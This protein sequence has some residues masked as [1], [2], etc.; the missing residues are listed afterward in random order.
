[1][2]HATEHAAPIF[3]DTRSVQL[4]PGDVRQRVRAVMD[5]FS[6]ETANSIL[7]MS[8]IRYRVLAERLPKARAA[9]IRQLVI[10]GAGLDTTAFALPAGAHDWRVF[11]VDHPATQDWKRA[12][13]ANLGWNTPPNLVYAPCDFEAQSL[14]DAIDAAGFDHT[15]PAVVSLFGVVLYL[16]RDAT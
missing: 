10:L 3:T 4:V 5:G 14:V 8:V 6:Q 7:L 12:R 2:T 1:N 16:T 13:I 11:E 9:G 15:R